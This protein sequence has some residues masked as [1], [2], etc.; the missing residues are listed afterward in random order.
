MK[1]I[2]TYVCYVDLYRNGTLFRSPKERL[3][4]RNT[5]GRYL[6]GAKTPELARKYLQEKIGFGSIQVDKRCN[7]RDLEIK[8]KNK[9]VCKCV[10]TYDENGK[11]VFTYDF[12][13]KHATDPA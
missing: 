11:P 8:L 7:R 13:V 2:N 5:M 3:Y 1:E 10:H 9:Q 6:V 12:N 4:D